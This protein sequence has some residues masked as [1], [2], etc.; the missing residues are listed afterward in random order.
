M[1]AKALAPEDVRQV[2]LDDRQ[3]GG[4][5][6]V[7]QRDRGMGQRTR[8]QNDAVGRF[9]R[10]LDPVDQLPFMIGLPEIDLEAECSGPG[11]AAL[12]DIAERVLP[13]YRRLADPE[14]IKIG[15]V[16]DED[17]G[18]ARPPLTIA[19]LYHAREAGQSDP[20]GRGRA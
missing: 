1:M 17:N 13:V 3:P 10:L 14:Q 20:S 8:V 15:A 11:G 12:L 9:A 18:Q 2:P 7:E 19:R 6:R 5:E 4:G 16:Q